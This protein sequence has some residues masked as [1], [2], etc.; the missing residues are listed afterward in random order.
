MPTRH[1]RLARQK[2]DAFQLGKTLG[3]GS[4]GR[5]LIVQPKSNPEWYMAVRAVE[6]TL[7]SLPLAALLMLLLGFRPIVTVC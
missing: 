5:V 2:L 7:P 6:N 1:A 3:T 4:F